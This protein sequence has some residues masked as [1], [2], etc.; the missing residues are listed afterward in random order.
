MP[1]LTRL[2]VALAPLSAASPLVQAAEKTL[3]VAVL[4]PVSEDTREAG[5]APDASSAAGRAALERNGRRNARVHD[6]STIVK[7][8]DEYWLFATGFGVASWRSKDLVHWDRGPRVF[9]EPP[10]WI[11]DVV[12][13]HRGRFWAPDVIHHKGRYWL[14][15]SISKFGVNTSAVALATSPTLDPADPEFGWTDCGIVIQSRRQ[16]D[17]N[18]IDPA[19]VKTP[20][21]RL[22]LALGSFWSGIKL[23]ELDPT[24][25]KRIAGD[26]PMHSLARAKAIEAPFIYR[27]GGHFYLFVNWGLCCRGVESTYNI[28]VGRSRCITGPYLDRCGKNLAEGGGTLLLATDGAFI[29]PGHAGILAEGRTFWFS[30]HFYDGT[31]RGAPTLAVRPLRWDC[32]G[33]PVLDPLRGKERK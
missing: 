33:W 27:H 12:P 13:G 1:A 16:D 19:V 7:C 3:R 4:Q 29:G 24:T 30:C 6:P 15:Y 31:R 5:R 14:Y 32:E 9:S 22:W 11:T 18:A 21:G 20:D 28:R 26:S 2:L 25:G 23:I 10:D 8:K 17:F